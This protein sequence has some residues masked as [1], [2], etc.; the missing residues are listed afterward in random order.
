[1]TRKRLPLLLALLLSIV[2]AALTFA[3]IGL[4]MDMQAF[5]PRPH[6][7]RSHF[8]LDEVTHGANQ[9]LIMASITTP[10]PQDLPV[11]AQRFHHALSS[12]D[13]FSLIL[14][15]PAALNTQKDQALLF[16]HRYGL[17]PHDQTRNFS[18]PALKKDFDRLYDLLQTAASPLVEEIGFKDPT[19]AYPDT[20]AALSTSTQPATMDGFWVTPDHHSTLM[21]LQLRHTSLD[22]ASLKESYHR[23]TDAFERSHL[24][25]PR[26]RL[27][28]TGSPVFSVMAA[29]S[30]R[31][32]MD[33]LALLSLLLVAGVLYWR[34]RSLW[35]LA[36]I[37]V[38]FLLSL[39]ASMLVLKLLF[40]WVHG[41]ALGFGMTMLGVSLDYPVL[42]LGHR[43]RGEAI[44]VVLNRIGPS[45]KMAA[46][47]A[48]VSLSS[49]IFCGLPGLVQ[50]GLFSAIGIMTAACVTLWIMPALVTQADLA[51]YHQGPSPALLRWEGLRRYR[52]FCWL[53]APPALALLV[54]CPFKAE[55][56]GEVLNPI[57][58]TLQAQD[59]T[60]RQQ[61][62][63]P[64]LSVIGVLQG[65]SRDHVLEDEERL[66]AQLPPSL[67]LE[68]AA[69]LLP[70]PARQEERQRALPSRDTLQA[71]LQSTV[72][73]TPFQPDS[74]AALPGEI[75]HAQ[76]LPPLTLSDLD[77]TALGHRLQF[78]LFARQQQWY[79][80]LL[81]RTD[82]ARQALIEHAQHDPSLMMISLK[83]AVGD[84]LR[85]H[86]ERAAL[87][88]LLG[89]SLALGAL[90]LFLRNTRRALRLTLT[91]GLIMITLLA[92]LR[93]HTPIF[94]I[95][96][97]VALAFVLGVAIDYALF[98]GRPQLDDAERTRTLRTLLTCNIMTVLSFGILASCETPLLHELGLT[99]S[100][101]TALSLGTSFLLMGARPSHHE[102]HRTA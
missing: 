67:S 32:D 94:S 81:P 100:I 47:T 46:F 1:M 24:N 99:I 9:S 55:R 58:A 49:M 25:T 3:S 71:A 4:R 89:T 34:F 6:D 19:G 101:G 18:A 2:V 23:I 91:L 90:F 40:G 64:S 22:T 61:L 35:V 20:L 11:I 75:T 43:D 31:H 83:T 27:T 52:R 12:T 44:S 48:T 5:L 102:E 85:P 69:S 93:L 51:T 68:A 80:V 16:A 28:L 77:G 86:I 97:L 13:L 70:S 42:L 29:H 53:V 73:N 82:H 15:G 45:L 54:L 14:D 33:R 57:P 41:I 7:A 50:L 17:A 98:F 10:H 36:T 76:T 84:L 37:A 96:H 88:L 30:L 78:L 62:G 59:R 66:L 21:L 39:S 95:I 8:L 63:A 38:P 92:I 56:Q 26:S 60:L 65:T 79:G 74:F 72:P 87:G